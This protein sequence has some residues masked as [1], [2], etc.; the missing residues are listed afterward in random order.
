MVFSYVADADKY[1]LWQ[2]QVTTYTYDGEPRVGTKARAQVRFL[3]RTM[4]VV[5]ETTQWD[6]PKVAA[7]TLIE[8]PLPASGAIRCE[9]SGDGCVV[10][11]TIEVTAGLGNFFGKI[12]EPV[13]VRLYRK[14]METNLAMLKELAEAEA[15]TTTT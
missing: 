7:Y 9:P 12:A 8:S 14:Q 15:G 13:V 6:P 4:D 2:A 5:G 11:Q 10:T 3:G 1:L